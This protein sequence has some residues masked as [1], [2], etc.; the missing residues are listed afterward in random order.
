[1]RFVY[2]LFDGMS[3]MICRLF[4]VDR[5]LF[6]RYVSSTGFGTMHYRFPLYALP[7]LWRVVLGYFSFANFCL[8][9]DF[10]LDPFVYFLLFVVAYFAVSQLTL[11]Y[12]RLC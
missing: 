9:L 1:M 2:N 10:F 8:D 5:F 11:P 3:F 12:F 6:D 4:I 7:C